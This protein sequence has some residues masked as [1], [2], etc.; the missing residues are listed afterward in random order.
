MDSIYSGSVFA[1]ILE[2]MA[3]ER[4]LSLYVTN[5]DQVEEGEVVEGEIVIDGEC[6]YQFLGEVL[7]AYAKATLPQVMA[8]MGFLIES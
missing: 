3:V 4:G 6:S 5:L 2:A 8:E 7:E 1:T